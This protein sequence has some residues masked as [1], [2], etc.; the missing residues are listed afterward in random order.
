MSEEVKELSKQQKMFAD[1]YLGA[2]LFNGTQSARQAGYKGDDNTLAVSASRLLR[3]AKVSAY[4]DEKLAAYGMGANEVLARLAEIARGKV[5]D[6]LDDRGNFDLNI[7]R[8]RN[9]TGLLKK[10]KHKRTIKQKKT[11]TTDSM[12]QF[13]AEDEIEDIETEVEVIYEEVEFEMYSAHEALRDL[14]KYHKLFTEKTEMEIHAVV[15][16]TVVDQVDKI[17]GDESE[18]K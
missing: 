8:T 11:E 4:I 7:A 12:R 6:L 1:S 5:D 13:L 9:K 3:N 16:Q 2:T 15:E 17:Y 14:G 10:L 18:N